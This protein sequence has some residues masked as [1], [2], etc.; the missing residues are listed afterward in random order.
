MNKSVRIGILVFL[1]LLWILSALK[2]DQLK[3]QLDFEQ[4]FPKKDPAL[5]LFNEFK[6]EFGSD[7]N[8][9]LVA[10]EKPD[11]VF[12]SAFLTQYHEFS[13]ASDSLPGI[14]SSESLTSLRYPV[15]TPL[16]LRYEPFVNYKFPSRYDQ[17]KARIFSNDQLIGNLISSDTTVVVVSMTTKEEIIASESQELINATEGLINQ[18][19]L[20]SDYHILGKPF[21][22]ISIIR[23]QKRE[24][25]VSL[26]IC[27]ALMILIMWV[28]YHKVWPIVITSV[29]LGL[30][31]VVFLGLLAVMG[32]GGD[33][34]VALYPVI[35]IIVGISDIVHIISKYLEELHRGLDRH[36]ALW[37]T[38]KEIGLATLITS[39]TTAIG[40]A[41]LLVT[42]V[43][44]VQI[45]GINSAL[46][47][48]ITYVVVMLYLVAILPWLG[49]QHF[50]GK[51]RI[52]SPFWKK[53]LSGT[54][55]VCVS[56]PRTILGSTVLLCLISVLGVLMISTNHKFV[57]NLPKRM[58]VTEDFEFFERKL[59]GF[60]PLEVMVISEENE[61]SS[62]EVASALETLESKLSAHPAISA[63]NSIPTLYKS[64]GQNIE[65]RGRMGDYSFPSDKQEFHKLSKFVNQ[66]AKKDGLLGSE[67]RITHISA[68]IKDIG[69]DDIKATIEGFQTWADQTLGSNLSV[70]VTGTG[71]LIDKNI[72]YVRKSILEG[73]GLAIV[74]IAMLLGLIFRNV[75]MVLAG[76]LPNLIPLILTAGIIGFV[77]IKLEISVGIV[78]VVA[79]GIAVDNT[80][81]FLTKYKLCRKEMNVSESIEKTMMETGKAIVLTSIILFFAFISLVLSIF[82]PSMV[83]GVLVSLTLVTAVFSNM[84]LLPVV[85][86]MVDR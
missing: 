66:K 52:E 46:G 13:K 60:R 49:A 22:Q 9:F 81:H 45:F 44:M 35:I 24:L 18:F 11:G 58:K 40:F 51:K 67:E 71:L 17:D 15:H 74:L 43:D 4:Y 30:S 63:V 31:I 80:I 42:D 21:I 12:D 59:N 16:M 68:V 65:G 50:E 27:F 10:F 25:T 39:V 23:M 82:P 57:F 14:V 70:F 36:K 7:D 61:V 84:L 32:Q 26:A 78:F 64:V 19:P 69:A 5:D 76:I 8:F 86:R 6:R 56:M 79:F 62:F 3:F 77:G 47:V 1:G 29:G 41:S 72:E 85:L 28:I 53:L 38:V 2:L 83:I 33:Q 34:L 20:L 37:I 55:S 48:M 73:L 54:H 75:K